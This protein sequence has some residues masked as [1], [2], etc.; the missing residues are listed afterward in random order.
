M[1]LAIDHR[2][3]MRGDYTLA[4]SDPWGY[5]SYYIERFEWETHYPGVLSGY[6][7]SRTESRLDFT[8]FG[9]FEDPATFVYPLASYPGEA[10]NDR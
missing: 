7:T 2:H 3:G 8:T 5:R 10:S 1:A 4:A 9:F 6:D